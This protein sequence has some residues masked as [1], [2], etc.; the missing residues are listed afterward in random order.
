MPP[1]INFRNMKLFRDLSKEE[2]KEFRQ[3]ARDNYVP[4]SDINKAYHPIVQ[5]ECEQINKEKNNLKCC[6]CGNIIPTNSFGLN[7]GQN[8]EPYGYANNNKCC[9]ECN[10]SIVIP[11]RLYIA[12]YNGNN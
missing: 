2:E 10:L 4:F 1:Y 7:L 8:A 9:D 6:L 12:N 11:T 3:W 5:D